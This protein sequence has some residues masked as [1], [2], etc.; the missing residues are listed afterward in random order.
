[1]WGRRVSS[2][3][4]AGWKEGEGRAAY[5]EG[6]KRWQEEAGDGGVRVDTAGRT[7]G[8]SGHPSVLAMRLAQR[9]LLVL[10]SVVVFLEH[11]HVQL[12]HGGEQLVGLADETEQAEHIYLIFFFFFFFFFF[13]VLAG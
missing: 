6:L 13:E 8:G 1:V 3:R 4:S 5:Q 11:L 7:A 9:R 2:W 12:P 10:Q